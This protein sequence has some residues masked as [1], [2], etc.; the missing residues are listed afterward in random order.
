MIQPWGIEASLDNI[1]SGLEFRLL[2]ADLTECYRE[3]GEEDEPVNCAGDFYLPH[4]AH[5]R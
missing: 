4:H 5:V 1:T 3:A 2:K